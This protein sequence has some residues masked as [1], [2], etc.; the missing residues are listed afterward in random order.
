[1]SLTKEEMD[2]LNHLEHPGFDFNWMNC[3]EVEFLN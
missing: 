1:M 2:S 3:L